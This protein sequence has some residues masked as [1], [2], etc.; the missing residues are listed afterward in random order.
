MNKEIGVGRAHS[1][2]ILIGEHAVV[3]GYPAIALPLRQTVHGFC[4]KMTPCP[5]QFLRLLSTS[6]LKRPGFAVGFSPWYRKNG[7]W[8]RLRR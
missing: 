3:Y 6:G 7:G 8:D 2:I 1:K 5:W 4:L